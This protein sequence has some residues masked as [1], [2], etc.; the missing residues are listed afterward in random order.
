MESYDLNGIV[1]LCPSSLELSIMKSSIVLSP[2][3]F[4]LYL[5]LYLYFFYFILLTFY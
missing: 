4:Y 5:V 2:V 3:S 1:Y